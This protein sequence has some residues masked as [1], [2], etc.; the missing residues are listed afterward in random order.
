[1][2]Y[3]PD[4]LIDLLSKEFVFDRSK[5]FEFGWCNVLE[6]EDRGYKRP[7]WIYYPRAEVWADS[8]ARNILRKQ[9]T[10]Y[11]K[12]QVHECLPQA[13]E[14][15]EGRKAA[16]AIALITGR[17]L[18]TNLTQAERD[19]DAQ[20]P[21]KHDRFLFPDNVGAARRFAEAFSVLRQFGMV[22]GAIGHQTVSVRLVAEKP[23]IRLDLLNFSEQD[24]KLPKPSLFFE[25][26]FTAPEL[27]EQVKAGE[28]LVQTPSTD[29]YS[30]TKYLIY[31]LLGP[32][33]FVQFFSPSELE[34]DSPQSVLGVLQDH[35]LWTNISQRQPELSARRLEEMSNGKIHSELAELLDRSVAYDPARRP[36]DATQFYHG[37]RTVMSGSVRSDDAGGGSGF[38]AAPQMA[39]GR[40]DDEGGN[41]VLVYGGIAAVVVVAVGAFF[42]INNMRQEKMTKEEL[43]ANTAEACGGFMSSLAELETSTIVEADG[44]REVNALKARIESNGRDEAL[45]AETYG[46]CRDGNARLGELKGGLI[47]GLKESLTSEIAFARERGADEA[48]TAGTA[49]QEAAA[50]LEESRDFLGTE[51]ALLAG[52]ADTVRLHGEAL[53][54]TAKEA[55]STADA[56][57]FAMGLNAP[58]EEMDTVMLE[59]EEALEAEDSTENLRQLASLSDNLT[60]I[61]FSEMETKARDTIASIQ[62]VSNELVEVGAGAEDTGFSPLLAEFQALSAEKLPDNPAG[63]GTL[64]ASLNTISSGMQDIKA[65]AESLAAQL[66]GLQESVEARIE[67]INTNG[68]GQEGKLPELVSSFEGWSSSNTFSDARFLTALEADLDER[69]SA[70]E[71]EWAEGREVCSGTFAILEESDKMDGTKVWDQLQPILAS[72]DGYDTPSAT[73]ETFAN[74]REAADLIQLGQYELRANDLISEMQR[75]KSSLDERGVGPFILKYA[76][77]A[78][79][80]EIALGSP[81]PKDQSSYDTYS[82]QVLAVITSLDEA[83]E[84]YEAALQDNSDLQGGYDALMA[85]IAETP[86]QRHPAYRSAMAK[87]D[88][89]GEGH[90]LQQN[91]AL[92]AN[93]TAVEDLYARFEAGLLLN[94]SF[95][96]YEMLPMQLSDGGAD[97]YIEKLRA[98]AEEA[99]ITLN[100]DSDIEVNFCITAKPVTREELDAYKATL[101]ARDVDIAGEIDV[102]DVT[103]DGS[104]INISYW[105]AERYA[106]HVG[107][108]IGQPVCVASGYTALVGAESEYE[109]FA[110]PQN[111]ELFFDNCG[112]GGALNQKLVLFGAGTDTVQAGCVSVN[113]RQPDLTFRLAAGDICR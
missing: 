30:L 90:I 25:P 73:R 40:D 33:D 18:D 12:I 95:E 32:E 45:L 69:V 66:P 87:L 98:T 106:N 86:L 9:L 1:M 20:S 16:G 79:A 8:K 78:A 91:A 68:W 13:I 81:I 38:A 99:G 4:D 28:D 44:W 105:L 46:F 24:E 93:I 96:G 72:V 63:F 83:G 111:G 26:A 71:E 39:R 101:R 3:D 34:S 60:E 84:D 94:C 65:R 109:E 43:M 23:V 57:Q 67:A 11:D 92:V 22:H 61:A 14:L 7:V 76:E 55:F 47:T 64:Y 5:S 80:Y 82:D 31:L 70:L 29:V 48:V 104:A 100:E 54:E 41:K 89:V 62:S 19:G 85:R 15:L 74:C 50:D 56:A 17:S 102:V 103:E 21:W 10:E 35:V 88:P 110:S 49:R 51:K 36:S 42:F 58:S 107:E 27:F 77:A 97:P 52:I 112:S 75:T 53:D 108:Q 37:L 113:R 59:L 6:A 2:A